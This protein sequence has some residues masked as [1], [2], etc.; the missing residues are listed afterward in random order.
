MSPPGGTVQLKFS[1]TEPRP[2]SSTGTTMDASGFSV[3]GVAVSSAS[4]TSAGLGVLRKG[5]LRIIAVSPNGDLGSS[6]D[7]PILTVT[8]DVPST[9]ALGVVPVAPSSLDIMTAT[10]PLNT[11]VR[12]G[13]IT[14]GGRAAIRNVIPGGGTWP[15]G[16][17]IHLKGMGFTT[18][19]RLRTKLSTASVQFVSPEEIAVTLKST[20]VMDGQ[21]FAIDNPDRTTNQYYSYLRGTYIRPPAHALLQSVEPAFALQ[22]W[23]VAD[24]G[25]VPVLGA[26]EF[27]G[28]ALQNP[29]QGPVSVN[30]ELHGSSGSPVVAS[31]VL[32]SGGR[33]MD[34]V[35]ELLGVTPQAGDVIR[36]SSTSPVQILGIRGDDV[37]GAVAPLLPR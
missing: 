18:A 2:I 7:Y 19:T 14:I 24:L 30:V 6:V 25:A 32:P 15:A 37:T 4:P 23:G 12:P 9:A 22:T 26:S 36:I 10:G 35:A 3:D 21:W 1:L 16:T 11:I 13:Q 31:F 33:L 28:L 5:K 27:L 29:N 20:T 8:M 17:V 34:G